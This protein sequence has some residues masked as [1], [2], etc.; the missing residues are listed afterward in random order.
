LTGFSSVADVLPLKFVSPAYT[1]EIGLLPTGTYLVLNVAVNTPPEAVSVPVP[2]VLA[3]SMKLTFPVGTP[4]PGDVTL[5][6]V[7]NVTN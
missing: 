5:T 7:V 1:A 6:V 4:P 2:M 3:P